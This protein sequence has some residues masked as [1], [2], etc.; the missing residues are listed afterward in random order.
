MR[1]GGDAVDLELVIVLSHSL[2]EVSEEQGLWTNLR[3]K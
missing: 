3:R 1:G 2:S